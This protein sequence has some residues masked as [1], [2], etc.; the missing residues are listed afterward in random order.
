MLA[1]VLLVWRS[2]PPG[3]SPLMGCL[4]QGSGSSAAFSPLPPAEPKFLCSIRLQFSLNCLC[5]KDI[6]INSKTLPILE[7]KGGKKHLEG[8]LIVALVLLVLI[9]MNEHKEPMSQNDLIQNR[10]YSSASIFT[11]KWTW[12]S[13][14]RFH[15][16]ESC[17][18]RNHRCIERTLYYELILKT[19]KKTACAS[20]MGV[21]YNCIE[22]Q[23]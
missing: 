11:S 23:C 10:L 18:P 2:Q 6:V 22:C 9:N 5:L 14:R 8:R 3:Q 12:R 19:S 16:F 1:Q 20:T 21:I 7:V 17:L 15:S 13:E 4:S